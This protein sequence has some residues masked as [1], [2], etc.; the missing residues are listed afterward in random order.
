MPVQSYY[1]QDSEQ[2]VVPSNRQGEVLGSVKIARRVLRTVIEQAALGVAGVSGLAGNPREWPRILG[3]SLP[4]HRIGLTIH[5]DIVAVEL[6][7]VIQSGTSM[8]EVGTRVQEAVAVA[9]EHILGM[10]VRE[11]NVYIQDVT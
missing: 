9:V 8:V 10:E 3:R 5:D 2:D 4:Q 6:Y 1:H 11:V 7:L